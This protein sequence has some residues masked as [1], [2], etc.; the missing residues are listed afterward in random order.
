[1]KSLFLQAYGDTPILRVLDF[2][3]TFEDYDYS[4]KDIAKQANVGYTTLK[5]F[6]KDMEAR[7]IVVQTRKV[8][9]A[10]MYK[11]CKET[12]EVKKFLT[13]Y[14]F[15]IETETERVLE[16]PLAVKSPR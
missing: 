2:L 16:K 5:S 3:I 4:M 15:V 7:N 1:M 12:P 13:F 6:W 8:G 9:K 11:L 14:W 10:K